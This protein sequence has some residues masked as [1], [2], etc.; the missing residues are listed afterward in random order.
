MFIHKPV[1]SFDPTS[2]Y[3]SFTLKFTVLI[4][5]VTHCSFARLIIDGTKT[6]GLDYIPNKRQAR[7]SPTNTGTAEIK[8]C[9]KVAMKLAAGVT[10]RHL[11]LFRVYEESFCNK[12]CD[13]IKDAW[14]NQ[15]KDFTEFTMPSY[16]PDSGHLTR[17]ELISVCDAHVSQ[18][19][20]YYICNCG[21]VIKIPRGYKQVNP[22]FK[23]SIWSSYKEDPIP[24]AVVWSGGGG[25][26]TDGRVFR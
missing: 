11:D 16:I 5:A 3:R 13:F 2:S 1:H 14:R 21:P 7:Y 24:G 19:E 18:T 23:F 9:S 17:R 4:A 12:N 8:A 26:S 25:N 15:D 10:I 6:K 22:S 20:S